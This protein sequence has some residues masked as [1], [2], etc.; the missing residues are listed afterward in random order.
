MIHDRGRIKWAPFLIPEHK[1]RIAQMYESE[2]DV[3]RPELDEQ[4]V[5]ELQETINYAIN[6]DAEVLVTYHLNNRFHTISG[7]I[8]KVDPFSQEIV[9]LR[10]SERTRIRIAHITNL[11]K[12]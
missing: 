9:L 7:A 11:Q 12:K 5:E 3:Q 2:E 4:F 8:Y 1:K 6:E 10:D